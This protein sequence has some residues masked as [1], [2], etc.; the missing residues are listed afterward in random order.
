MNAIIRKSVNMFKA[1]KI[2]VCLDEEWILCDVKNNTANENLT[3][4]DT[5]SLKKC[6][7]SSKNFTT[8]IYSHSNSQ[9]IPYLTNNKIA[10]NIQKPLMVP[11]IDNNSSFISACYDVFIN[12]IEEFEI[13]KFLFMFDDIE[14]PSIGI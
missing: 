9:N 2:T 12:I 13:L 10:N 5:N 14:L 8:H 6:N 11:I 7:N 4:N 1:K 3:N